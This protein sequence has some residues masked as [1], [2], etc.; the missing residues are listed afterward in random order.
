MQTYASTI[1][2]PNTIEMTEFIK[3][4]RKLEVKY[5]ETKVEK[6]TLI[7]M[8][9]KHNLSKVGTAA[10]LETRIIDASKD[11]KNHKFGATSTEIVKRLELNM[12]LRE[13]Y[14][15]LNP[16]PNKTI[17]HILEAI[18]LTKSGNYDVLLPRV[19][20]N[21]SKIINLPLKSWFELKK[22]LKYKGTQ[23]TLINRIILHKVLWSTPICVQKP[24][25]YHRPRITK[26]PRIDNS[27]VHNEYTEKYRIVYYPD[28][29]GIV[30]I[31]ETPSL[32]AD[33]IGLVYYGDVI[34]VYEEMDGW[35]R[36]QHD[37]KIG[38]IKVVWNNHIMVEKISNVNC[39]GNLPKVNTNGHAYSESS[40][41]ESSG[42]DY[43]IVDDNKPVLNNENNPNECPVCYDNLEGKAFCT[44]NCKHK[45]C[46]QCYMLM[47]KKEECPYCRGLVS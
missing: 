3:Y 33:K 15:L 46:L 26:E 22:Q 18:G 16:L 8:C 45:V 37:N 36:F 35:V 47:V 13:H 23:V 25:V 17:Q 39:D 40:S 31:R 34:D 21:R 2:E 12:E 38:Y 10:Q 41:D 28:E 14:Y 42:L 43:E 30:N 1:Y 27:I 19:F 20:D 24:Q 44:L 4:Y 29:P 9:G 32:Y 7:G 11:K 6:K 5:N